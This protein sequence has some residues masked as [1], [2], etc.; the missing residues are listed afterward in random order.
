[1]KKLKKNKKRTTHKQFKPTHVE[2]A[3]DQHPTYVEALDATTKHDV[4]FIG[5]TLDTLEVLARFNGRTHAIYY[6]FAFN[7]DPELVAIMG[8]DKELKSGHAFV[9]KKSSECSSDAET[10]WGYQN[11]GFGA[12]WSKINGE[13]LDDL[14]PKALRG[15]HPEE[16]W[17][18]GS[19]LGLSDGDDWTPVWEAIHSGQPLDTAPLV[20]NELEDYPV[21]L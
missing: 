12:R 20:E 11:P 19:S 7:P 10:W 17:S 2:S 16:V 18:M 1:M 3:T 9:V 8:S 4:D 15:L 14:I 5:T 21:V 13:T 6:G